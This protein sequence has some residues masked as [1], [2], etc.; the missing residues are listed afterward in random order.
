MPRL[1]LIDDEPIYYK[2]INHALKPHHYEIEFAKTGLDGL[3]A[4]SVF[5]PDVVI[6][7]VR[8][9]DISG[10][11]VAQRLR[12]DPRF[13]N[14]PILFLT[15]QADLENKIKAFESGADDYISKPFQPEELVARLAV[16]VRRSEA[17]KV[18]R[19]LESGEAEEIAQVIAVHSLRGGVGVSSLAVNFAISLAQIWQK[20]TL[21]ID[22]VLN[23]G[24]VALMLNVPARATWADL[25]EYQPQDVDRTLLEGIINRHSSGVDFIAAP[26][27]PIAEDSF[28][29]EFWKSVLSC[30]A[31]MYEFIVIDTAHNFSN[32][33][34]QML[35]R[36]DNILVP[37]APDMASIRA[38]VCALNIF[39]KLNYH[40]NKIV[41]VLNNI[42]PQAG[43]KQAQIEKAINRQIGMV[44]PYTS[45]EFIRAINFVEPVM[46]GNPNLPVNEV[47][48]DTAF[49]LSKEVLKNIPPAAPSAAWK[50]VNS[51]M[52]SKK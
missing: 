33:S 45:L 21:I 41:P 25:T 7:D 35:D 19:Q 48:E 39:D 49:R 38:A 43:I 37:I 2:M 4:I 44:M 17:F 22:A 36:A 40:P 8:L 14:L 32:V 20:P 10:Y 11:E 6:T 29:E 51:R 47:I 13:T 28:P 46:L 24:Q 23:A 3:A 34:I 15:S 12:R 16:L 30:L 31:T 1:L 18:V 27:F 42:F 52:A 5:N 50:R 26:P 9:P